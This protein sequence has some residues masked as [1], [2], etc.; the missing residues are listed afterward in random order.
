MTTRQGRIICGLLALISLLQHSTAKM[1]CEPLDDGPYLGTLPTLQMSVDEATQEALQNASNNYLTE[2]RIAGNYSLGDFNL[3]V[4]Y[5][6]LD[7]M[8]YFVPTTV[9]G[10]NY[11]RLTKAIDRD[12]L[13]ESAVDDLDMIPFV[14]TCT[15]SNSSLAPIVYDA[16]IYI[17]DVNDNTPVFLNQAS[18]ISIR[19][20]TPVGSTVMTVTAVDKDANVAG[21]LTYSLVNSGT[22]FSID[23]LTGAIKVSEEL[24]YESLGTYNFYNITV[25]VQDA[26]PGAT[27]S[28]TMTLQIYITDSDDQ[29]PAFSYPGCFKYGGICAWPKFTTGLQM[30]KDVPLTIYPVP[31]Q[32]SS[33]VTIMAY[34]QDTGINNPVQ[35]SVASTVPPGQENS[36]NIITT[37]SSSNSYTASIV[38]LSDMQVQEGFE[39]FLR[40]VEISPAKRSV[41]AMIY[42]TGDTPATPTTGPS[43]KACEPLDQGPYLGTL[44]VLEFWV[45]EATDADIKSSAATGSKKYYSQLRVSGNY[46]AGDFNLSIG[47]NFA[48]PSQYFTFVTEGRVNYIR[49]TRGLDRDGMTS[50][51]ED[52]MSYI[53]FTLTCTPRNQSLTTMVYDARIYINDVNDNDPVFVD[54]NKTREIKIAETTAIGSV[55]F[56]V[57]AEDKDSNLVGNLTFTFLNTTD[58]FSI[59]PLTGSVTLTSEL[60][61]ELLGGN[62]FYDLTIIVEDAGPVVKRSAS[63]VSRVY[64]MDS[65]DQDPV[66]TYAGCHQ[67]NGACAWPKYTTGL[68][69]RKNQPIKVQPVPNSVNGY[70]DITAHDLDIDIGN[71]ITFSIASTFP[72]GKENYFKVDTV[73]GVGKTYTASVVSLVDM[74]LSEGFQIFLKAEEMSTARRQTIAMIYFTTNPSA[75]SQE[76]IAEAVITSENYSDLEIALIIVVAIL[77]TLLASLVCAIIIYTCVKKR[78][79]KGET[80]STVM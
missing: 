18:Q 80:F 15:P 33:S 58:K 27:R 12:G 59:D 45:D 60:D 2:L 4:S 29:G 20:A 73:K 34:D 6:V 50:S 22:Q 5:P 13:T 64:V 72:V 38:P 9:A 21:N 31:N 78:S 54:G 66:F 51:I 69:I 23:S 8:D 65:D 36:F 56:S 42:F 55:L 48:D 57:T 76:Q 24:D 32:I 63:T 3:S 43:A 68:Q 47:Y 35:F 28:N 62:K 44:P 46:G 40:A 79:K 10:V 74:V 7:P 37:Q 1:V 17:N 11:F 39:I 14:L 53:P 30:K 70:V 16:K 67:N 25:Q 52:D 26:G 71:E 41:M 75:E 49:L 61:Y 77:A 19:E